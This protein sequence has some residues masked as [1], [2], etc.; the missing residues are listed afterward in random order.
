[1]A[2]TADGPGPGDLSLERLFVY[3]TLRPRGHA[4]ELVRPVVIHHQPAVLTGYCLVGEGHRYPWCVESPGGEVAGDL[5]WL[6]EVDETLRRLDEYE[7]VD[8]PAAEYVRCVAD[9]MT[10]HDVLT[11]WVYVGGPGVPGDVRPVEGVDW[12]G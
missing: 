12:P 7:G 4:F 6:S 9:V 2:T 1:M 8:G 11:A 5:L 10:G 3:G